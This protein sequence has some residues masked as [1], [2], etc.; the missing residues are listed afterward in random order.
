MYS[1]KLWWRWSCRG[2]KFDLFFLF[3]FLTRNIEKW[4]KKNKVFGRWK[5]ILS[6]VK[7]K[8]LFLEKKKKWWD[9]II[10]DSRV[11]ESTIE[12]TGR[13][14]WNFRIIERLNF[15]YSSRIDYSTKLTVS[16]NVTR[17]P[18][19]F[20]HFLQSHKFFIDFKIV[21]YF[22]FNSSKHTTHVFVYLWYVL[23]FK[24]NLYYI[25]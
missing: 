3:F 4:N 12:L 9:W 16:F 7:K 19:L 17:V 1:K 5:E 21:N 10:L 25:L 15:T 6:E 23:C 2:R 11:K 13:Q 8:K 14:K 24:L 20:N 22:L 18:Y